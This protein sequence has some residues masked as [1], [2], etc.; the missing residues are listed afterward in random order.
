MRG[1]AM[2]GTVALF[3]LRVACAQRRRIHTPSLA[4]VE[5][6]VP[7]D[8]SRQESF[9][10][11]F[12]SAIGNVSDEIELATTD[13][14]RGVLFEKPWTSS[15]F[16]TAG[17]NDW[18][19]ANR[20]VIRQKYSLL[21]GA[22]VQES[23]LPN[24][25][26]YYGPFRIQAITFRRLSI[27]III[28]RRGF[29]PMRIFVRRPRHLPD[30][31]IPSGFCVGDMHVRRALVPG[32]IVLTI[33]QLEEL[34]PTIPRPVLAIIVAYAGRHLPRCE[35]LTGATPLTTWFAQSYSDDRSDALLQSSL[36]DLT[37]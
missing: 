20:E 9:S 22:E 17:F 6:S 25:S 27:E 7:A 18:V 10:P 28:A 12:C 34:M 32:P 36:L 29:L 35:E 24:W 15:A 4:A 8:A 2:A 19:W 23:S 33:E 3:G 13:V 21:I 1:M 31:P 26:Q 11:A 5:T 16:Y 30:E 14:A 37:C